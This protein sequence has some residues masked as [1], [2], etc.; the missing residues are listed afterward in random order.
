MP[1]LL[2]E[3]RQG[4]SRL[5]YRRGALQYEEVWEFL[6]QADTRTQSRAEIYATPGLPIVGRSTTASG[7]AVCT[8]VNPV[9]DE[10]AAL[11]WRIA[12]TYSSDVEDGQTQTNSQGQPSSNPLEWVPVYETKFER[13]QEIVT[14]DKNGDA[15][16]NSAGQAFETGLTVSRFIPVWEFYQFEPD[17]VTDETIIE[18]NETVNSGTFKGRAAKTLLLTVQESVIWQYLGQRVRLTKYSLKYNKKDWTHKR[19]D[20]GTQ[21]LDTGTL[22]DFTSTDGT[23][24]LGSLDGSGGQQTAGDPPAIVTFDQYDSSD[25]SFLRL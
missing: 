15:I 23:I 3:G 17:T 6:V 8:S 4:S 2:G 5:S 22:K 7:F 10:E 24:M 25:F 11:I 16:A 14:K 18:R 21:Y 12:V 19:L 1:T 13:L 9:R 20:V